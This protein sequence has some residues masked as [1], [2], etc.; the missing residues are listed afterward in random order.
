VR[1]LGLRMGS[2]SLYS[3]GS[4]RWESSGLDCS[5]GFEAC[6]MKGVRYGFLDAEVAVEAREGSGRY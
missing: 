1:S 5:W 2:L 6:W 4:R 3:R